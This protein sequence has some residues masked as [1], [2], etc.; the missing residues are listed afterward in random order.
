MKRLVISLVAF[1]LLAGTAGAARADILAVYLQGQGGI[2]SSTPE[3]ATQSMAPSS[4]NPGLGLT[5]G[6]RALI[7]EGYL[8]YISFGEGATVS[9]GILGL[10][11]GL[12]LGGLRLVL[13]AGAGGLIEK[14]GAL[15]ERL[16]TSLERH[17]FVARAGAS[18]EA[19]FA[20]MLWGGLGLDA[21]AFTLGNTTGGS[22]DG[23]NS[24]Q[25]T[26]IFASLRLL[27]ELGI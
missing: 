2:S 26:D 24:V 16:P 22:I 21:E 6:A 3:G 9:R 18:L 12:G 11:A 13:R 19:R 5:L 17:G 14:G 25:G 1:A 8:D 20:P 10:R 7:F 23:R 27:F 4:G 15:T